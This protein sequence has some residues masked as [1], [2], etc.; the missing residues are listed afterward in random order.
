[1]MNYNQIL[2]LEVLAF[3]CG[4]VLMIA[5]VVEV[6]SKGEAKEE[7]EFFDYI[8]G[9]WAE[10]LPVFDSIYFTSIWLLLI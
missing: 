7:D 2:R 9:W 6:N 10:L 4:S 1:M 3:V 5:L 8:E